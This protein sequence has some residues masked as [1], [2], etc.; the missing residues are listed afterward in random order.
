MSTRTRLLEVVLSIV[1][2]LATPAAAQRG[3]FVQ[4]PWPSSSAPSASGRAVIKGTVE[5]FAN[6]PE[7]CCAG[8]GAAPA[9]VRENALTVACRKA[10]GHDAAV[11]KGSTSIDLA[12]CHSDVLPP[13][14]DTRYRCNAPLIGSCRF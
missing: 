10:F 6:D 4:T 2:L 7:M 12:S 14:S 5:N 3:Q 9:S 11:Q 13:Q 8:I 1:V